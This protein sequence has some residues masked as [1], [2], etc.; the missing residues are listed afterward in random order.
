M[1][2]RLKFGL[3]FFIADHKRKKKYIYERNGQII[4]SGKTELHYMHVRSNTQS[5]YMGKKQTG[6]SV[7]YRLFPAEFLRTYTFNNKV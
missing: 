1:I 5:F 4:E 7:W 2:H 3:N 6:W